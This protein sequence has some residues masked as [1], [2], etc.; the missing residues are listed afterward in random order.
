MN[1]SK[2]WFKSRTFWLAVL[3]ISAGIV[4]VLETNLPLVG[5]LAIAKGIIDV[6]MRY[7]TTTP[8]E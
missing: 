3:T 4:T 8:L 6:F 5:W 7:A 1:K 2:K